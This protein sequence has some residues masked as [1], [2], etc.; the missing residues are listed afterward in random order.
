MATSS[1][2]D[3]AINALLLI[4]N[5]QRAVDAAL[6]LPAEDRAAVADQVDAVRRS[7][8]K[9]TASL[10]A[11]VP[12][13][14]S[15]AGAGQAL[16]GGL[17][18]RAE[19][20]ALGGMVSFFARQGS[21]ALGAVAGLAGSLGAGRDRSLA[22]SERISER[23]TEVGIATRGDLARELEVDPRAP[24]FQDALERTLG[25]GRAEWY[26]SGTYGL[27]R[28]ELEALI[29]RAR[30]AAPAA[31]AAEAEIPVE[32]EAAPAAGVPPLEG[33][34]DELSSSLTRLRGAL[35]ARTDEPPPED[36][37]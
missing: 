11:T 26:G 21:E 9:V 28:D 31:E 23:L 27:P 15:L 32:P 18:Q 36:A 16:G 5:A 19:F 22:L 2:L 4:R 24:E 20:R 17:A 13:A 25:S 7:A 12:G 10:A 33:A 35:S 30:D 1:N 8:G 37:T 6:R 34:V 29:A 14:H 3:L